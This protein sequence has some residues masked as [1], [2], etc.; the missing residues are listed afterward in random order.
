MSARPHDVQW[1]TRIVRP[2]WTDSFPAAAGT[3]SAGSSE[4]YQGGGAVGDTGAGADQE[5]TWCEYVGSTTG[6]WTHPQEIVAFNHNT[7]FLNPAGEQAVGITLGGGGSHATGAVQASDADYVA[8]VYN[9]EAAKWQLVVYANNDGS[10]PERTDCTVQPAS[11]ISAWWR[12]LYIPNDPAVGGRKTIKCYAGDPARLIHTQTTGRCL[13]LG[14]GGSDYGVGTFAYSGTH[15]AG[16]ANNV[17][18]TRIYGISHQ[19]LPG[20]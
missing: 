2:H 4:V 8:L 14:S 20:G 16:R 12:L 15:A 19:R 7:S 18:W 13:G 5:W 3:R 1:R 17:G 10:A 9:N 6:F 11:Y